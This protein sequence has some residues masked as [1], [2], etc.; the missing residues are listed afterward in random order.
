MGIQT[1]LKTFSDAQLKTER[2]QVSGLCIFCVS[3]LF[4][5][6]KISLN[7]PVDFTQILH[8]VVRSERYGWQS[9][10]GSYSILTEE[11][12]KLSPTRLSPTLRSAGQAGQLAEVFFQDK[13]HIHR[14]SRHTKSFP[15]S[16]QPKQKGIQIRQDLKTLLRQGSCLGG[17]GRELV[18]TLH[19][20]N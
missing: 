14:N 9:E 19:V 2:I 10:E 17:H 8:L 7:L 11:W 15:P 4:L 13:Q 12:E 16:Q 18:T 3:L 1:F 5:Q 6:P 20:E